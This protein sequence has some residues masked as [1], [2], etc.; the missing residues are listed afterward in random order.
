[1]TPEGQVPM[2]DKVYDAEGRVLMEDKA[3]DAEGHVLTA[4]SWTTPCRARRT[5]A[6][7]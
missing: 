6:T 3:Y 5:S 4:R 1:M 2:E 7:W